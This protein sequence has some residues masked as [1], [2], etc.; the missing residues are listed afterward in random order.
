MTFLREQT[1]KSTRRVHRCEACGQPMAIGSEA[2]RWF[3]VVEGQFYSI[4]YHPDCREA[5][6]ALN[7]LHETWG[8]EWI[9]LCDL[10]PEDHTWL[11]ETYPAV[12]AR[13]GVPTP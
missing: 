13:K 12:A 8:D 2:Y 3:G 7:D 1:V 9:G 4:I 10:D 11:A 6:N 5:E